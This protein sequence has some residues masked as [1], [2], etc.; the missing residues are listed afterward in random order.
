MILLVWVH[1]I[2]FKETLSV[3]IDS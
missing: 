3:V 2:G 1:N